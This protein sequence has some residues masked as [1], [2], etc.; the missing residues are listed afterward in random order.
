MTADKMQKLKDI[1][2]IVTDIPSLPV[3][4]TK[5]LQV[6]ADEASSLKELIKVISLDQSFSSRLLR[7]ANSAFYGGQQCY[8][9]HRCCHP[10]RFYGHKS[11]C[12]C[13]VAEGYPSHVE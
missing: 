8:R 4:A 13:C 6:I 11:F 12:L 9:R 3:V 1:S 2:E 5:I 7:I 10:Y